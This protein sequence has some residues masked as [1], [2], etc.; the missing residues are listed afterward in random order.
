MF[1][2]F[3]DIQ[4]ILSLGGHAHHRDNRPN[5]EALWNAQVEKLSC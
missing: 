3:Q 2:F 5:K 1:Q 4:F